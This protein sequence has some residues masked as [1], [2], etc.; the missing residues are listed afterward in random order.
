[1]EKIERNNIQTNE[2]TLELLTKGRVYAALVTRGEDKI[3][4]LLPNYSIKYSYDVR[5]N[6][7]KCQIGNDV[8]YIKTSN[9]YFARA[10]VYCKLQRPKRW[11][12]LFT[13][14]SCRYNYRTRNEEIIFISRYDENTI[15]YKLKFLNRLEVGEEFELI[16]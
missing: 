4:Q 12:I 10:F 7:M 9:I 3:S 5:K 6:L 16:R 13:I 15:E 2:R 8:Y 11:N 1:M 14:D